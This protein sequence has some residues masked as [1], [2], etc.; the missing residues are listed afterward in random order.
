MSTASSEESRHSSGSKARGQGHP[1]GWGFNPSSRTHRLRLVPLAV[2]GFCIAL[3]LT[4]CQVGVFQHAWDPFFGNGT[5]RVIHSWLSESFPLPDALLGALAYS[6]ELLLLLVGRDDR[7]LTEPW[8]ALLSGLTVLGLGAGSLSLMFLQP[9]AVGHWCSLCLAA[10]GFI[11]VLLQRSVLELLATLQGWTLARRMGTRGGIYLLRGATLKERDILAT[12]VTQVPKHPWTE[13]T[14]WLWTLLAS[15]LLGIGALFVPAEFDVG[16]FSAIMIYLAGTCALGNS[17]IAITE[18]LRGLRWLSGAFGAILIF[19]RLGEP[20]G[21]DHWISAAIG[22]GLILLCPRRGKG[23]GR[24]GIYTHP[25]ETQRELARRL[26]L[27][28]PTRERKI[29]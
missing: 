5:D 22:G 2:P 29:A 8:L 9:V 28:S 13:G 27:P 21:H 15:A 26:A 10:I 14:G 24:Y 1:L 11:L 17:M 4:L 18:P 25:A 20:H 7:W 19:F 23:I 12:F 3:Y 6:V 16:G